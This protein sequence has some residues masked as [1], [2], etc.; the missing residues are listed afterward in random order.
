MKICWDNLE[1]LEYRSDREEWQDKRWSFVFYVY[2][3]SC[4]TC[5]E[6]FL[7]QRRSKGEFCDKFCVRRSKETK[8]KMS[9]AYKKELHPQYKNGITKKGITFY[10]TYGPQIDYCEKVKRNKQDQNILEV[11]CAYCGK[12]YIPTRTSICRRINALNGNGTDG[13][14]SRLYCSKQ[15]KKECPIYRKIKY[16]AEESQT[17]QYSREVQPQLRQ[18]CFER[19][20]YTCQKCGKTQNELKIGLNCHHFTGVEIN[21]I[22]SADIDNCITLCKECHK[23]IHENIC[24]IVTMKRKKC[25]E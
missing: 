8:L 11:K 3:N 22:E 4:K 24:P 23:E 20:N 6:P 16:S 1:K 2:K 10:D 5:G 25:E 21:P 12:W 13:E 9:N 14:E 18:M 15:C 19:D 7:A 17:K